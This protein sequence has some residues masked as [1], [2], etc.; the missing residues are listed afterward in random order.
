MAGSRIII[1]LGH[2]RVYQW[3][4]GSCFTKPLDALSQYGVHTYLFVCAL[5]PL[6]ARN[7]YGV[8]STSYTHMDGFCSRV[9]TKWLLLLEV[10]V[11]RHIRESPLIEPPLGDIA[12]KTR[13]WIDSRET[14]EHS[15][16]TDQ[17]GFI[18][19]SS[20]KQRLLLNNRKKSSLVNV[21]IPAYCFRDIC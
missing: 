4:R 5:L 8:W 10:L 2:M 7:G 17:D 6:P 11:R 18:L 12:I 16:M 9:Y 3:K 13:L 19:T 21:N 15:T 14:F 1:L 20:N